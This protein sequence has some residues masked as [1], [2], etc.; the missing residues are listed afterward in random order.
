[1]KNVIHTV[2]IFSYKRCNRHAIVEAAVTAAIIVSI[3]ETIH[4]PT[5]QM[6][7]ELFLFKF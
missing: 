5:L 4:I 7:K 1:M 3:N 2:S 6:Y